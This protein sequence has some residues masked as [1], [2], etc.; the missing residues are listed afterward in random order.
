VPPNA[1]L[2]YSGDGLECARGYREVK[3][4]VRH[5]TY[6]ERLLDSN[7][8]VGSAI[9][10]TKVGPSCVSVKVPANAYLDGSEA[11]SNATE[12]SANA[13][14]PAYPSTYQKKPISR[15]Q[16]ATGSAITVFGRAENPACRS[17]C[18]R[19]ATSGLRA[20]NGTATAATKSSA[21]RAWPSRS[22]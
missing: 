11:A 22:R 2:N 8:A 9:G 19:T 10:D 7:D 20:T 21:V 16:G 14:T 6:Q 17:T 5:S 18:H 3:G 4:D 13:V 15:V 12:D 1:F